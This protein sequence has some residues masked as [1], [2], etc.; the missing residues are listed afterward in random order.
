MGN[1]DEHAEKTE[2]TATEKTEPT[3]TPVQVAAL[4]LPTFWPSDPEL[5]FAQVEAQ[6][7][8][9]GITKQLTK[10]FHVVT[11]LSPDVAAEVRDLVVNRPDS[12]SA[13]NLNWWVIT[14]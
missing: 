7:A 2:P 8:T 4:K 13:R 10:I 6:F 9:R 12:S 3:A 14:S 1:S 5:W 11:S